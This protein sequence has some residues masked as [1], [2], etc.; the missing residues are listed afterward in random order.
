MS[1][2]YW[3]KRQGEFAVGKGGITSDIVFYVAVNDGK[4]VIKQQSR[5]GGRVIKEET[6]TVS[7]IEFVD[8]I[9]KL[10]WGRD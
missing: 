8:A 9:H 6:R 7:L 2:F 5:V 4:V 1:L 3:V 10:W